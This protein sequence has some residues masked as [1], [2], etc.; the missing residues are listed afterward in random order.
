M[1]WYNFRKDHKLTAHAEVSGN[2]VNP[3]I[4]WKHSLG[5]AIRDCYTIKTNNG[6]QDILYVAGN[7]LTRKNLKG[8]TVW[9][10]K[11]FGLD[12]ISFIVDLDGDGIEEIGAS[13]GREL[14]IFSSVTGELLFRHYYGP[15]QSSGAVHSMIIAHKFLK[16]QKGCQVV[17]ALWS[18]RE[19]LAF[20]FSAGARNG[21]LLY[22][23]DVKDGFHPT[24]GA[25][26]IDNC[27]ED[28][29]FVTKLGAVYLIEF[30]TG[31]I[32]KQIDWISG[33]QRRRNYGLFVTKDIDNDG[34][35]EFTVVSSLVS[36]HLSMVKNDGKGNF[37]VGW[38]RFIE[39]IY[40]T[41]TTEV[42]FTYN[43]IN[44]VDGDGYPDM[45]VSLYNTRGDGRWYTEIVDPLTGNIKYEIP[46]IFIWGLQ[47]VDN[48]GVYE[49]FG[50]KEFKRIQGDFSELYM[51]DFSGGKFTEKKIKANAAFA[52][53]YINSKSDLA[54]FRFEQLAEELW[55]A[56]FNGND[57]ILSIEREG[58]GM[59]LLL[60]NPDNL[61]E[62]KI[63]FDNTTR[64]NVCQVA[65]LDNDGEPEIVVSDIQGNLYILRHTGEIISKSVASATT[66]LGIFGQNKPSVSAIAFTG[67][68][69][70]D[71]FLS[72]PNYK[73]ETLL[74]KYDYESGKPKL[75]K[76]WNNV[77]K[78]GWNCNICTSYSVKVKGVPYIIASSTKYPY[79]YLE[80]L[81]MDGNVVKSYEFKEFPPSKHDL[82]IGLYEWL[83]IEEKI[84]LVSLYKSY[85]MNSEETFALDF[86]TGEILWTVKTVNEG[87]YGKG[88]G[89]Y[90]FTSYEKT[91]DDS[92]DTFLMAKDDI[93]H[94]NALDGKFI[95]DP[96][97][98]MFI[99][100]KPMKE[101]GVYDISQQSLGTNRDPF[102]AYGS[103]TL[104]DVNN[105]GVDELLCLGCFNAIGVMDMDHNILWWHHVP[106]SNL[107]MR[108]PG[109]ADIDND[110]FIEIGVGY[111]TG[112]FICH[113]G[114]DGSE[115]WRV[116][117]NTITS[118]IITGD[119][120]G[121]G[122]NEFIFGTA[123]GRL[124]AIGD[125]GKIKFEKKFDYSV[126]CPV[127]FDL[128]GDGKS[129]LFFVTGDSYINWMKQK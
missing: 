118:D 77:G 68:A 65:D 87:E 51:F 104:A 16:D 103:I 21:K 67:L 125:K 1:D 129:E 43:S 61:S 18:S 11:P 42:R 31:K 29:I 94:F 54:I 72:L 63:F 30:K 41:D 45:V 106:L 82:R 108:Y 59:N 74:F 117:L 7:V 64:L 23:V 12:G 6:K 27:G 36:R 101:K 2:F 120:D 14:F 55:S 20:D 128:D 79:S 127:M 47:D 3:E 75:I 17:V 100:E 39:H 9:S 114:K 37:S 116:E 123:D 62:K 92:Y 70:K 44:D 32:K 80:V 93:C 113:N 115:K 88:F 78:R 86:E 76:T 19:I 110:G 111:M 122:Y 119:I 105:D 24:I 53:R 10:T 15:P 96:Q 4:E 40:P 97:L 102:T 99:T 50:S 48:D 35:L 91:R 66:S 52:T 81:D 69:P 8:E 34:N 28:E 107:C 60:V 124:M 57:Y 109:V 58:D 13:N 121:D 84:L 73:G 98:M 56:K 38:D 46:D 126:G 33:G 5:G 26:D 22:S 112:T 71:R 95:K 49:I 89:A 25:A 83:L 85:S 90:G